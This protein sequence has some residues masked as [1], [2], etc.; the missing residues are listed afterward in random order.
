MYSH[1]CARARN[2]KEDAEAERHLV[3]NTPIVM[4]VL[5]GRIIVGEYFHVSIEYIYSM[6]FAHYNIFCH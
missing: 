1:S 6:V 5:C 3:R 4:P 2:V